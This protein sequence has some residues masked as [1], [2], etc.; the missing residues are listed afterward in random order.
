[1]ELSTTKVVW[2]PSSDGRISDRLHRLLL[3]WVR[4]QSLLA[5][6]ILAGGP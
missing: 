1:M 4:H 5:S 2:E 3:I 6:R